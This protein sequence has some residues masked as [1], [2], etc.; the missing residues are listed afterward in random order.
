MEN[1]REKLERLNPN[2]TLS[3]ELPHKGNGNLYQARTTTS[4][5]LIFYGRGD[6]EEDAMI[7]CCQKAVKHLTKSNDTVPAPQEKFGKA[8]VDS[9]RREIVL[10][11]LSTSV[12]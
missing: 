1:L 9:H 7:K 6:S 8:P 11:I 5:G 2:A 4:D 3:V 10:S 12:F